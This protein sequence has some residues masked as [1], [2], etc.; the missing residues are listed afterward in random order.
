M[1]TLLN[2]NAAQ[3]YEIINLGINGGRSA[4]TYTLLR[5]V[6]SWD[7]DILLIYDGNNEFFHV[8]QTFSPTLWSSALYRFFVTSPQSPPTAKSSTLPSP[9]GGPDQ[10]QAVEDEFGRTLRTIIELAIEEKIQ[11]ILITQAIHRTGY[12]PTWSTQGPQ[13][14]EDDVDAQELR[15]KY[16]RS[17]PVAWNWWRH[18]QKQGIWDEQALTDSIDYDALRLRARSSIQD[19]IRNTAHEKKIELIDVYASMIQ[20][21][22]SND[23]LFYDWVHPTSKGAQYIAH[24]IAEHIL[25]TKLYLSVPQ[26][27]EDTEALRQIAMIWLRSACIREYDPTFRLAQARSY[28]QQVLEQQPNDERASSVITIVDNWSASQILLTPDMRPVFK[29]QGSC[30]AAKVR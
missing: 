5:K 13:K 2:Q 7:I 15:L 28:A 1:R 3:H 9:Y 24:T 14:G 27:T 23:T 10:E 26:K 29:Q 8:P 22:K 30:L 25:G 6:S 17:A 16:P 18:Q 20:S 4:D 19:I 11:P 12:D 21:E